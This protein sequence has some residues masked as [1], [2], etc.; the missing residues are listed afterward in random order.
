MNATQDKTGKAN[1]NAIGNDRRENSAD[2]DDNRAEIVS[3][4][5]KMK[6]TEKTRKSGAKSET[7]VGSNARKI[8]E[9]NEIKAENNAGKITDVKAEINPHKTSETDS[10]RAINN[11]HKTRE[12][13]SESKAR[14][15]HNANAKN[16]VSQTSIYAKT[17]PQTKAPN[18]SC[19]CHSHCAPN[20][21]G[22]NDE[23]AN[24]KLF[25]KYAII[26]GAAIYAIGAAV[27]LL[28]GF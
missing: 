12:T 11:A 27:D 20:Q 19:S 25:G 5:S 17:N 4:G 6:S 10:T 15:T 16:E 3:K 24:R 7:N 8:C 1:A 14:K 18:S 9:E 28:Y 26:F 13:N 23:N 21:S 22:E 2:C